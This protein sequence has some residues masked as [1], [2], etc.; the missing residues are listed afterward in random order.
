MN[1]E[2]T[3]PNRLDQPEDEYKGDFSGCCLT[4]IFV[5]I[6]ITAIAGLILFMR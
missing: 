5:M 3:T 4:A 1:T 6:I 2:Y